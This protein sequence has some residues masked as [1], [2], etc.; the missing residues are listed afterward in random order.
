[1]IKDFMTVDISLWGSKT[2]MRGST[3][4]YMMHLFIHST[5][6]HPFYISCLASMIKRTQDEKDIL[7][8]S[9]Q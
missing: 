5:F 8:I 6:V 4:L 2:R 7:P 9:K 1:M 3:Q